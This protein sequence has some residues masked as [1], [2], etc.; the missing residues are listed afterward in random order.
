MPVSGLVVTLSTDEAAARDAVA[1]LS[2][3]ERF[4]VGATAADHARRLPLTLETADEAANRAC[5]DELQA[6][7]GIEFA[8]VVCVFFA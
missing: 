6:H 4:D 5:W 8:D 2:S 7:P 3:D 1:W